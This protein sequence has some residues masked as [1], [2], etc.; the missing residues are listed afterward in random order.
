MGETHTR[1]LPPEL[2]SE[3]ARLD[4]WSFWAAPAG[5]DESDEEVVAV[6]V[7]GVTGV[8]LIALVPFEGYLSVEG[9]R[10]AVDGV[11]LRGFRRVRKQARRLLERM[12]AGQV[13][14]DRVEPIICLTRAA[15]G[16]PRSMRG[17]TILAREHLASHI[18]GRRRI[19]IPNQAKKAARVIGA[20][21]NRPAD[22]AD[23]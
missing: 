10:A 11:P 23:A 20:D 21:P 22:P 12:R 9:R 7:A 13:F 6:S 17:V 1:R 3:L 15:A 2:A 14:I 18:A 4:P 8:F 5:S 16:A 19:L